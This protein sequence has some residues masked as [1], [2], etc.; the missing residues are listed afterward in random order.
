MHKHIIFILV[1]ACTV[2]Q[3]SCGSSQQGE[4][5]KTER[6]NIV[7]IMTDD[8][9]YQT[10]SAYD[11][12]FI[13]TPNIDRIAGEG[14]KF[15]NSFVGN[16]ICAPSRATL[17]TGKHSHKNGQ[18]DNGGAFDGSQPTFP[19]YLQQAGYQTALIGKWHLRSTPTG[20]D[21]YNR[22]IGQGDYYNS[23]FI[24]NGDTIPSDGYVTDVITDKSLAWLESRESDQPFALQIHH[25]ASHRVWMPDTSLLEPG[26]PEPFTLPDMNAG[27]GKDQVPGEPNRLSGLPS[28]F[29][30]D[31][32]GRRAAAAQKMS[33]IEDM[34]IVYDLKMLD[35]EGELETKYRDM[36]ANGRYADLNEEQKEVWDAYYDPIIKEF[37]KQRDQMS[38]VELARWKYQRY[39]RDYLKTVR[40]VDDNV[41]RV[42]DYLKENDLYEN[43]LIVY[44]SDQGF[45]MGEH[46][47]FDKRFMYEE[48]MRTP[49]LMKFPESISTRDEVDELVQN[50]DYAPTLLDIAGTEVPGDMQGKSLLPLVQ[51]ADEDWREALYYH[52]Y[53]F[54]NPHMVK[55]HYGIRTDRYKLIHF[56]NDIDDWELYD[57]QE[58]PKEMNDLYG[59]EGYG[60]ITRE[61]KEKL[62]GL[63]EKYEDTDR[64]TY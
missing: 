46:G 40:T 37:K 44:T 29:F 52:Y 47:W 64:S 50:I 43:T 49:L 4:E 19:K 20:Y 25:K 31:Y 42:L 22:L 28:T 13:E 34:D 36:Y 5:E 48:S 27:E 12:R 30:D 21:H 14:V 23:D 38:K 60:E 45:Y 8:H 6:P 1:I 11:D 55:R 2:F 63:Q 54:P 3:I 17:L 57:L 62:A 51:H 9:S 39:M 56:Y 59:K 18:I 15:V 7:F 58:D 61:L 24:V 10:L 33:I 16:S 41:G 53:E 26:G 35:E 32:E